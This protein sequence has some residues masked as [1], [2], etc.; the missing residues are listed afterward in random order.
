MTLR[1]GSPIF[2]G[3][4]VDRAISFPEEVDV[5]GAGSCS[6]GMRGVTGSGKDGRGELNEKE[7]EGG[8]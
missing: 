2:Y 5:D 3:V 8:G 7:K 4:L 1:P 6:A